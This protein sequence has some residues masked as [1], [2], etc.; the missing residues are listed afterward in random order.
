[1][2][3]LDFL[4]PAP[5][6]KEYSKEIIAND[7]TLLTAYLTKDDKWRMKA[8]IDEISQNLIKAIIE[9]E[10]NWFLWHWG[11]N[12]FSIVRAFY[13]NISSGK[14]VSGA[15]TITMQLARML[16]PKDRNYFSKLIEIFRAFQ[17]E[18]H[19]SKKEILEMY[20]NKLPYGG[21]I[22]GVKAASYIYFNRPPRQLSL[23]QS[24]LLCVIPNDPNNL[25]LD[26]ST[27]K[28]KILRNHWIKRFSKENIF[29]KQNLNDALNEPVLATRNPVPNRA[30]HFSY[31]IK[32]HYNGDK[33]KT[34]L[35]LKIQKTAQ[36]LLWN[37]VNRV[38]SKDVSNG[39]VII[40]DNKNSSVVGYCGSSDFFD[41]SRSGQ[42]NGITAVRSPGSTLKPPLYAYAFDEGILTPKMKLYDIPTDFSG[43]EP[44]N[45]D[46][47]YY[48]DVTVRFALQNSL[49]IPAV[50]LLNK[51]GLD[52]FLELLGTSGFNDIAQ[53]KKQLGLSV[54]L[55]GCGV[56]LEELTR[57]YSSFARNGNLYNL[58][59]VKDDKDDSHIKLF[60]ASSSYLIAKIL[61]GSLNDRVFAND[62]DNGV[63]KFAFKTGTSYGKRDAWAIG[64]NKHYTIGVWLG[65]FNG[66]G[67]P[68]LSG[69][70]M[71]VPLLKELFNAIDYST[72]KD[73]FE[74]PGEVQE[75]K[76]CSVT[77]LLPT[78]YCTETTTDFYIE[79]ISH[80]KICDVHKPLYV[81]LDET[82]QYCTECLPETGFKKKVY[83]VYKPDLTIWY[84][85]ND[86]QFSKPPPH[87][88][89]CQAKYSENGPHIISPSTNFEYM[90]EE[91]SD[92]ELL[93]M[94]ESD[95]TVKTHYWFVNNNYYKKCKPGERVFLKA[96]PGNLNITCLDDKGRDES[97]TID[98]K[99]Y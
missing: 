15:S 78:K 62:D 84:L 10:D 31:F 95:A 20:L 12:P 58:H 40:V 39:A 38:S 68:H 94:A 55:G 27:L 46:L 61:S 93:L 72:G 22:E 82:I 33:I 71:A 97:I 60:S 30:P 19:Y 11:V 41:D 98:V 2:F 79:G 51:I 88:P 65:N 32:E 70:E 44:E 28:A 5:V 83:P 48:G 56:T 99:F 64:F 17:L 92:Q 66:K 43:Y 86:K 54:I 63:T 36:G 81:N 67:S 47:K 29:S 6:V 45:Y 37:Y 53:R 76:V 77:G 9:K 8:S 1:M 91:N 18:L 4:F 50:R 69:A 3:L 80:N 35:N 96:H 34:T 74:K 89:H 87:N 73:W 26:K 23:S 25:R 13:T 85:Q 24:I 90:I 52:N 14:R 21:N 59:Y 57:L 42:V 49:N 16:E 75:R 7:G